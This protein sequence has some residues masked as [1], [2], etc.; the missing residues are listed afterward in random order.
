[1]KHN[2]IDKYSSLSSPV[3]NLN[4]E[5]K[6]LI[7]FSLAVIVSLINL[8]NFVLFFLFF[9]LI[10]IC[11]LAKIQIK[12]VLIRIAVILPFVLLVAINYFFSFKNFYKVINIFLKSFVIILSLIL[13]IQTTKFNVFIETLKSLKFP[14]FLLLLLSFI[15]RYFFVITDEV[16]KMS[17]A[18]KLRLQEK[19]RIKTLSKIVGMILI[20][21]FERAERINKAMIL[22]GWTSKI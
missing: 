16:E 18:V 6:L 20:R 12:F 4:T 3:H 7:F 10:I 19:L 14:N 2:F 21:S 17:F 15:Y 13:L 9:V 11:K 8:S 22:R 1:M 5:L